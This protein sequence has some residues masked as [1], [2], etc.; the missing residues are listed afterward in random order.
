MV[1]SVLQVLG[2]VYAYST[3]EMEIVKYVEFRLQ[4][5]HETPGLAG[6]CVERAVDKVEYV[7]R[8]L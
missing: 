8:L 6:T 7:L 4:K 3:R 1:S 5:S 2:L